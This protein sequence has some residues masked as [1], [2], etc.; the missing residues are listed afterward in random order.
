MDGVRPVSGER[1]KEQPR[2]PPQQPSQPPPLQQSVSDISR[3]RREELWE[4]PAGRRLF[5]VLLWDRR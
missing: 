3:H 1:L 4:G 2:L 5:D